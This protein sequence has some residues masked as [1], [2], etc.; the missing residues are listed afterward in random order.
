MEWIQENEIFYWRITALSVGNHHIRST[1]MLSPVFMGD[2][3]SAKISW[4]T[5]AQQRFTE[6]ERHNSYNHNLDMLWRFSQ[7]DNQI[8]KIWKWCTQIREWILNVSKEERIRRPKQR[9]SSNFSQL[10]ILYSNFQVGIPSYPPS[11]KVLLLC[12]RQYHPDM[13]GI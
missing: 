2:T 1:T 13:S 4:E 11:T 5:P 12:V 3:S 10:I 8:K 9:N 7:T 6:K